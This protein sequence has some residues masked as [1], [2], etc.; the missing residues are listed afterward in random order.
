MPPRRARTL[1]K[2]IILG[3]SRYDSCSDCLS[4]PPCVRTKLARAEA[5]AHVQ[6]GQ[7]VPDEPVCEQEVLQ[8]VQGHHR[9]RLPDQGG[10]G[11]RQARHHTGRLP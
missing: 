2:V 10:Q 3:D 9:G 5:G 11:G 1:L 4:A 7:D 8:P 6:S